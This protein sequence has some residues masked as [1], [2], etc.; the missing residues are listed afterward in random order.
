[1][2]RYDEIDQRLVDERVVQFR[3]QTQRFQECYLA[4]GRRYQGWGVFVLRT[5]ET[6]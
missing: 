6:G 3:E 5:T 2:Y 4:Y 1:M